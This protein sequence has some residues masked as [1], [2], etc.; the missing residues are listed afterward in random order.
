MITLGEL[1]D[2]LCI[3][4]YTEHDKLSVKSVLLF[5]ILT[6]HISKAECNL[7]CSYTSRN[8]KVVY[9][10]LYSL[11]YITHSYAFKLVCNFN[12]NSP[13]ILLPI[14]SSVTAPSVET[15][16]NTLLSVVSL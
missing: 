1:I 11:L 6:S 16:G 12:Y 7:G 4:H 15:A 5:L 14:F 8:V 13:I 9:K 10:H 2:N 3:I